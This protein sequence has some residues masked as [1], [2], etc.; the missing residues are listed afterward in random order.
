[1]TFHDALHS[2][3][4]LLMDGAMGTELMSRGFTAPTWRANLEAPELVRAIHA[5]FV[6]AGAEV[7]L[8]NTFALLS[9]HEANVVEA[10]QASVRLARSIGGSRWLLGSIGPMAK[11][12][13]FPDRS[14]LL[15]VV[16]SLSGVD[17]VLLET[18][19]D[20]SVFEAAQWIRDRW[21]GLPVL[22]SFAFA[23]E[24]DAKPIDLARA[25]E[26]AEIAAL[27]VNCG[28]EQSPADVDR[29]LGLYQRE[30]SKPLFARPNA[31][32]PKKTEEEWIYPL[33]PR[34]WADETA[35]LLEIGLAM[36]GGCCG[37]GP[38]HIDALRSAIARFGCGA[39]W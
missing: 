26:K 5:D 35:S 32:S 21:P 20:A 11:G 23:P 34:Q 1:M 14:E 8:T 30:S 7:L 18:C 37:V 6:G 17:G 2:G 33:P 10:G 22:A 25:A 29:T 28:R 15:T 19:S 3:R 36:V 38:M 31:G 9:Q 13:N 24:Q 4:T 12:T 39:S 27:G 16:D